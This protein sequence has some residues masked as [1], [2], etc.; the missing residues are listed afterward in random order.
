MRLTLWET[1]ATVRL[2]HALTD[3]RVG[4]KDT[5]EKALIPGENLP[6]S[7]CRFL[8]NGLGSQGNVLFFFLF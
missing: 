5:D 8:R 1:L 3:Q 6:F 4:E 7:C 2:T